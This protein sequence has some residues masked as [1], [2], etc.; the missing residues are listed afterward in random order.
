MFAFAIWDVPRRKPSCWA[1]RPSGDQAALTTITRPASDRASFRVLKSKGLLASQVVPK[2][3]R[4]IGYTRF[5]LQLGPCSAP[6]DGHPGSGN[7]LEPGACRHLAEWQF[8]KT[9]PYWEIT[10]VHRTVAPPRKV[11]GTDHVESFVKMLLESSLSAIDVRC[12]GRRLFLSGGIDS[13]VLGALMKPGQAARSA[14]WPLTI[15][16]RR[17]SI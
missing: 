16:F 7:H 3:D 8:P 2:E 10:H 9:N 14:D 17:R 13:A 15:G 4:P 1:P 5:F 11:P 12:P 6:L